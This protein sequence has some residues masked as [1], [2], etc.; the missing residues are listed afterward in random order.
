VQVSPFLSVLELV[1]GRSKFGRTE[2]ENGYGAVELTTFSFAYFEMSLI[3]AKMH[4][5]CDLELVDP[6]LDWL[7][8]SCL[9]VMW[10]KPALYIRF[11]PA[12]LEYGV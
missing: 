8:D 7:K 1:L 6:T 5:Q 10:W 3:L 2:C 9:H 11:K 4:F 12:K